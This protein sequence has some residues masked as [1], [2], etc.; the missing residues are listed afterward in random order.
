MATTHLHDGA[1]GL[2]MIFLAFVGL[3]LFGVID[4]SWWAVCVPLFVPAL[5]VAVILI[6]LFFIGACSFVFGFVGEVF[7]QLRKR[8]RGG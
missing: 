5:P 2:A 4:W 6:Y 3:K 1:A 7:M 8:I